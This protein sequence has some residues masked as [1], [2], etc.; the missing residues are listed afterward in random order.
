[1]TF[2][3]ARNEAKSSAHDLEQCFS[4]HP[5]FINVSTLHQ[6]VLIFIYNT[7]QS[8]EN[9]FSIKTMERTLQL[10]CSEEV[11][12]ILKSEDYIKIF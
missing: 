8:N 1:M 5:D 9:N 11:K 3:L 12:M 10:S 7:C 6:V 4:L 2:L